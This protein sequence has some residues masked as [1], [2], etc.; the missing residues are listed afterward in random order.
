VTDFTVVNDSCDWK[1]DESEWPVYVPGCGKVMASLIGPA[2]ITF[3]PWCGGVINILERDQ[4][5]T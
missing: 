3:C 4:D 2:G 1:L 5:G